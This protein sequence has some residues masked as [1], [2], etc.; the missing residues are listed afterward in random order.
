M[1]RHVK[2]KKSF[3]LIYIVYTIL[4]KKEIT[5]QEM[6][7]KLGLTQYDMINYKNDINAAIKEFGLKLGELKTNKHIRSYYI[8]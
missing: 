4:K 7:Q 8:D 2:H 6:E 1:K 3:C 5:F